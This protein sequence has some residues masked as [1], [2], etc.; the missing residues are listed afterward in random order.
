MYMQQG[1]SSESS[2]EDFIMVD[3][4]PTN[5]VTEEQ[6]KVRTLLNDTDSS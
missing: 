3:E 5:G 1:Y 2:D 6:A 4:V